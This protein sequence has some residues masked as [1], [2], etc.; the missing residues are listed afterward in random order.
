MD[1]K[2][3]AI[4]RLI[5]KEI[6]S[7]SEVE[8]IEAWIFFSEHPFLRR[9]AFRVAVFIMAIIGVISSISFLIL[10]LF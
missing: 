8:I 1:T 10:L 3:D 2:E 7:E 4:E 9:R 6:L 5:S